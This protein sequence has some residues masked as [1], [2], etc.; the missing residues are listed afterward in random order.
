M[1]TTEPVGPDTPTTDQSTTRSLKPNG[2]LK[3]VKM[4]PRFFSDSYPATV[5]PGNTVWGSSWYGGNRRGVSFANQIDSMA[6]ID[7]GKKFSTP[8]VR[9]VGGVSETKK[10]V[11]STL[12]IQDQLFNNSTGMVFGIAILCVIVWAVKNYR[13]VGLT[14]PPVTPL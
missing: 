10:P 7:E 13:P 2:V 4:P 14:G 1:T 6:R 3:V 11:K 9:R 12:S 8:Q 5:R